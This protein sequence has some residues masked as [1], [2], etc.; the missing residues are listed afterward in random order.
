MG[1]VGFLLFKTSRPVVGF[2]QP[3]S[4]LVLGEFFISAVERQGRK[5]H[6]CH[7]LSVYGAQGQLRRFK[8]NVKEHFKLMTGHK[9]VTYGD[10]WHRVKCSNGT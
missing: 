2:T 10:S 8:G 6:H 5:T 4:Q 7:P 3:S 9:C 1:W